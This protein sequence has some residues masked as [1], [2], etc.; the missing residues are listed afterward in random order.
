MLTGEAMSNLLPARAR[1]AKKGRAKNKQ[2]QIKMP[3]K[4]NLFSIRRKVAGKTLRKEPWIE[5]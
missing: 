1:C 5:P 3:P 2:D 4:R